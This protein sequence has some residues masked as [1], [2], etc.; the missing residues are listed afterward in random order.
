M[1]TRSSQGYAT[2]P[3]DIH[4]SYIFTIFCR[5][6]P[7][8]MGQLRGLRVGGADEF[9]A[10]GHLK[11]VEYWL[12]VAMATDIE[13]Y[14]GDQTLLATLLAVCGLR[15]HQ[16]HN[17][18]QAKAARVLC[19]VD[20][21]QFCHWKQH[22]CGFNSKTCLCTR[23]LTW[24]FLKRHF[25]VTMRRCRRWSKRCARSSI[26]AC[27]QTARLKCALSWRRTRVL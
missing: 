13:N 11:A 18:M 3:S 27:P 6:L 21:W 4:A 7:V 16:Q 26:S 23:R 12:G 14:S 22:M 15:C 17:G 10:K 20:K 5:F 8:A 19:F 2:L 25:G 9:I 1:R 24:A